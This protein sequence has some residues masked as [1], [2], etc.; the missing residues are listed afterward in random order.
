MGRLKAGSEAE[1]PGD[2]FQQKHLYTSP[3]SLDNHGVTVIQRPERITGRGVKGR[4]WG[5]NGGDFYHMEVFFWIDLALFLLSSH[6]LVIK[7]FRGKLR[8]KT[9]I[10]FFLLLSASAALTVSRLYEPSVA[11]FVVLSVLLS[12]AAPLFT[13]G[14]M[15]KKRL[16]YITLLYF[17]VSYILIASCRWVVKII[18]EEVNA[19]IAA[20]I[21]VQVILL[22]LCV[23]FSKNAVFS[24]AKRYIDMISVKLKVFL[25]ISVWFNVVF[26][27]FFSS[28][29]SGHPRTLPLILTE[30]SA[31]AII[32][33]VGTMWPFIILGHSLNVTYKSALD[34]LDG[35]IQ[36]QVKHYE[37]V[38]QA[39]KDVR[40]FRHDF[41]NLKVGLAA[42]LQNGDPQGALRFLAECEQS[43]RSEYISYETGNLIAD[44]LLTEKET[45]A[46]AGGAQI[47]F[48]G[49]I[50]PGGI[51]PVDM[52]VIL[53]NL[54][55]N[56]LEACEKLP[57]TKT[58]AIDARMSNGF[59]FLKVSNPVKE[60]VPLRGG[61]PETTKEDQ[62]NHGAGLISVENAIRNYNGVMTLSCADGV[63][64]AEV[65]LDLNETG[66]K[67]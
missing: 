50:P 40:G 12:Y 32:I 42:H 17:G 37:L 26:A 8:V 11:I 53:G 5:V 1:Q 52:C 54:L 3:L 34:R 22:I 51:S 10:L 64:T 67:D 20:G 24:K 49:L 36:A 16:L 44:A 41:R 58:A 31:A 55:D 63:F 14:N 30:L 25:L 23:V 45:A 28:Y 29:V 13:L 43:V 66:G 4:F 59:L 39:N 19:L 65:A 47:V 33:S 6:I 62:R 38:I 46:G 27:F 61:I 2:Q 35:Q 9:A 15:E 21:A 56:A 60:A 48:N 18:T 7:I 57:G